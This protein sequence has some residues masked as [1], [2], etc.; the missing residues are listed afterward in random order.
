MCVS[1]FV[2]VNA[3]GQSSRPILIILILVSFLMSLR[4]T[5]TNLENAGFTLDCLDLVQTQ[6]GAGAQ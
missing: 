5:D 3:T 2:K 1:S 4:K 6:S